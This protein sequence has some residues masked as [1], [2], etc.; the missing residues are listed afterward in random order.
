[1]MLGI[2]LSRGS[3][4]AWWPAG[5][6]L[7]VDFVN[8]RYMRAGSWVAAPAVFSFTRASTGWASDGAGQWADFAVNT[9]RLT[10]RGLLIEPARQNSIRNNAMSGA[11]V[12]APGTLPTNWSRFKSGTMND[13]AVVASGTEQGLDYI[14]V[15]I[16]GT[17]TGNNDVGVNM[18]IAI[19]VAP[20]D[21]YV[22][23]TFAKV[24][25]GSLAG[26][27]FGQFSCGRYNSGAY[28][29]S[30]PAVDLRTA[31]AW[32]QLGFSDTIPGSGVNQI[33]PA[34]SFR[35]PDAMS[36]DAVVRMARPQ[37]EIGAAAATS[38][39]VTTGS[40]A[41]RA[42]D[43]LTLDLPSGTQTLT[44]IFEDQSQQVIT[45]LAG[46][47]LVL[48]TNLNKSRIARMFALP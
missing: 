23:S 44:V 34:V 13:L 10:D 21:S 43:A 36:V 38:P 11:V 2:K 24:I 14:D 17:A 15:R 47:N 4:A 45:G 1:M 26:A 35:I 6:N 42:A 30:A 32:V 39:I 12:G 18:E 9:P 48:P 7:A 22:A 25:S 31:T 20:G 33:R 3:T 5:A 40:V 19:S 28:V 46:G 8:R 29:S 41:T 27:T 16:W 37:V